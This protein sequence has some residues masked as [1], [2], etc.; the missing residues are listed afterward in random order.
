MR[1][2][3]LEL[4]AMSEAALILAA[5]SRDQSA[6][7]ELVRRR[8][9]W[10]RALL[11]RLCDD[12]S[13]A[14]DLAQETFVRVWERLGDLRTPQAFGGWAR[15][16]AVSL[17]MQARRRRR[18]TF[19]EMSEEIAA[20]DPF[21][22]SAAGARIDLERAL[23]LLSPGERLCVTLNLGEG[24]SHGD[25]EEVTGMPLGTIKSHI[26]RGTAKLRRALGDSHE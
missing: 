25:I 24:L 7:A 3:G 26:A 19:S 13:E 9:G 2:G 5:Q 18:V 21:P 16:V 22:D 15:R 20:D 10:L 11:R 23:A 14:D 1:A 4:S 8:Q 17:F 6:F 12:A